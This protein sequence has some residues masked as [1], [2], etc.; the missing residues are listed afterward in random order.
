MAG[1]INRS[2]RLFDI[3]PPVFIVK[4]TPDQRSDESAPTAGASPAIDIR[5]KIVLQLYVQTHVC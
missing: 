2:Q 4:A 1:V 5:Y 3:I